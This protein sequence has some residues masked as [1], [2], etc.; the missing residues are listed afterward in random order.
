MPDRIHVTVEELRLRN[1]R[2]FENARLRLSDVTFLVGRNGAGKSSILDAVELLREAV[3]DNLENAL[4]RRGGILKVRRM[5]A[6]GETPRLGVAVVLGL[7]LPGGRDTRAVYG[8]ELLGKPAS[9]SYQIRE[10]L[11]LHPEGASF[12]K[13]R[14]KQ[15]HAAQKTGVS[16]PAGNLVLPLVGRSD[17]VWE[18]VYDAVRRMYWYD[19]SAAAMAASSRIGH[20]TSLEGT[21]ANAGDVLKSIEGTEDHGWVLRHLAALMPGLTGIRTEVLLGRRVLVFV[22]EQDGIRRELDALQV[23]H[24]TLRGLG[25]LL[26]FRQQPAP[27]LVLVD[28]VESSVHPGGLAV[29]FDAA[30]ASCARTRVVLTTHS[31][32]MLSHPAVTGERLRVVEWKEG[33]S[34]IYLL[35][36]E[37]QAAISEI[38]TVGWMLRSNALWTGPQPET[39]PSDLLA[40]DGGQA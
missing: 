3:T 17:S 27:A 24:G 1:F 30:L 19:L 10:C 16:P 36:A 32:E 29:L 15:F 11:R 21:G 6:A 34:R 39:H 35:S 8:F 37:T 33:T 5:A 13:R 2:A 23:S 4:D 18:A 12:F 20:G 25:V 26:A 9:P 14:D 31:P 38:D 28:E 22:Q 40:I 7:R